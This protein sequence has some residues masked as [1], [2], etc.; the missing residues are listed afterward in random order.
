M[1]YGEK[2]VLEESVSVGQPEVVQVYARR[3]IIHPE[4]PVATTC[5]FAVLQL[6]FYIP[7]L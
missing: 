5:K 6:S 1:G 7:V 2:V 3:P 4:T